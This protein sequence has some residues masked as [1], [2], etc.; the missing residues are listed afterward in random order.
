MVKFSNIKLVNLFFIGFLLYLPNF[1]CSSFS[2]TRNVAN[3]E[4]T[5]KSNKTIEVLKDIEPVLIP[6]H[7]Y[8]EEEY[9]QITECKKYTFPRLKGHFSFFYRD[10]RM[11]WR[12]DD[13]LVFEDLAQ[14]KDE[15]ETL[16]K[17][18][19]ASFNDDK[20][21]VPHAECLVLSTNKLGFINGLEVLLNI[22][23][24]DLFSRNKKLANLKKSFKLLHFKERVGKNEGK[25]PVL[26]QFK[27]IESQ[28]DY[29]ENNFDI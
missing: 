13:R 21:L 28:L 10:G 14:C 29:C 6:W 8:G 12:G 5:E 17:Y 2:E 25:A 16:I 7:T 4:A 3:E 11:K 18:L 23:N 15:R 20:K 24:L 19:N 9:P 26:K 22:V 27:D 1:G